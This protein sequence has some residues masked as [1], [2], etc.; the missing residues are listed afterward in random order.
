[1]PGEERKFIPPE[2]EVVMAPPLLD[3]P[4]TMEGEK[5]EKDK[6]N[7]NLDFQFAFADQMVKKTGLPMSEVL[8][9]YTNLY[10]RF[11]IREK[12]NAENL[13]WKAF[14]DG[15][16]E[17]EDRTAW[18]RT[19]YDRADRSELPERH[20]VGAFSFQYDPE[21]QSI[22]LH[23]TGNDEKDG[24]KVSPL[25]ADRSGLR[26]DEL[27]ELFRYI[28]DHPKDFPGVK[29]V[30]GESWLHNIDAYRRL[31]PESY[32]SSA[33]EQEKKSYRGGSFWGQFKT[34][35][36]RLKNKLAEEFLRN[37]SELPGRQAS[38]D[39]VM[40]QAPFQIKIVH[41]PIKD[42]YAFYGIE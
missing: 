41:A 17:H 23:F 16:T 10:R 24:E 11:G 34:Y 1:M 28:K 7:E 37:I 9:N 39:E 33:Q 25:G 29:E 13:T 5:Q 22:E 36:G 20:V 8:L 40:A 30:K 35:K 3:V 42:F 38:P 4:P 31:Y 15:L 6:V 12:Y 26:I 27:K 21:D 2:A 14:L 19:F 32:K 18:A